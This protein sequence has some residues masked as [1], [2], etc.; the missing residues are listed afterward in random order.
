MATQKEYNDLHFD[1]AEIS[2]L[3]LRGSI[4][5]VHSHLVQVIHIRLDNLMTAILWL[6]ALKALLR[7]DWNAGDCKRATRTED[8]EGVRTLLAEEAGV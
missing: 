6:R 2:K 8:E 5:T 4:T 3:F 1:I 7:A